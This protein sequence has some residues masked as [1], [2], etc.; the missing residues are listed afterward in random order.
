MLLLEMYVLRNMRYG[1]G[2]DDDD[3]DWV[4]RI[5]TP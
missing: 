5:G 3:R 4:G 2:S 1:V